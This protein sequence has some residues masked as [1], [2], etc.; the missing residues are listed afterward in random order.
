MEKL[1]NIIKAK[2]PK[3]MYFKNDDDFADFCIN[4]HIKVYD[5]TNSLGEPIKVT[6]YEFTDAYKKAVDNGVYFCIK[7]LKS[8]VNKSG[9]L[10]YRGTTKAISNVKPY[11]E[12]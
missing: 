4:P 6:D 12:D 7:D 11:Y 8:H 9:L 1:S 3:V 10:G 5:K 2:E